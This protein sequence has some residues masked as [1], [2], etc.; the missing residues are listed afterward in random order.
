MTIMRN[1]YPSKYS[2][3]VIKECL[4]IKEYKYK[5]DKKMYKE[6]NENEEEINTKNEKMGDFIQRKQIKVDENLVMAY[7][8]LFEKEIEVQGIMHAFEKEDINSNIE[9]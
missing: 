1:K 8:V 2:N 5:Y 4:K 7:F 9:D 6:K 3:I